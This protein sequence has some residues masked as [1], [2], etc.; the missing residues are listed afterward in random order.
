MSHFYTYKKEFEIG[1]KCFVIAEI[2]QNHQG[3]LETAK[4]MIKTAKVNKNSTY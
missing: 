4:L 1:K 2:G 3:C